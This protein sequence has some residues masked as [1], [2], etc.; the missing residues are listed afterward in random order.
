M[1]NDLSWKSHEYKIFLTHEDLQ[2]F[3]LLISSFDKVLGHIIHKTYVSCSLRNHVKD[4]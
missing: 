1:L 3:I 4:M 2:V